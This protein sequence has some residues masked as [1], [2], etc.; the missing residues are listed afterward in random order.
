AGPGVSHAGIEPWRATYG[1][2]LT[3]GHAEP[4]VVVAAVRRAPAP[5]GRPEVTRAIGPTPA[6]VDKE[7][8]LGGTVR[9]GTGRLCVVERVEE[10]AAPLPDIAMHVVEAEGI[11]L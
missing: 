2:G 10:I 1:S 8:G 11:G 9:I 7:R 6:P 5:V 4:H 3:T